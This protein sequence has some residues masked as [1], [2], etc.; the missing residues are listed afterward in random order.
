MPFIR[1]FDKCSCEILTW[2]CLLKKAF[3]KFECMQRCSSYDQ[4]GTFEVT[5][6]MQ[7]Q[8][9]S[10]ILSFTDDIL[11]CQAFFPGQTLLCA[12]A[13]VDTN[14]LIWEQIRQLSD[15]VGKLEA[16][17]TAPPQKLKREVRDLLQMLQN[18]ACLREGVSFAQ[19]RALRFDVGLYITC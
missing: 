6:G 10:A 12:H 18:G 9:D 16:P 2:I 19:T 11:R 4:T 13:L 7:P 14:Q 15:R 8:L 3:V 17:P 5:R 1:K